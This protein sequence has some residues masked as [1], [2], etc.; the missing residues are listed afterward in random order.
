[1]SLGVLTGTTAQAEAEGGAEID[2]SMQRRHLCRL[3]LL[4]ALVK[5][6]NSLPAAK[7]PRAGHPRQPQPSKQQQQGSQGVTP[8]AMPRPSSNSCSLK[9]MI[10]SVGLSGGWPAGMR[11]EGVPRPGVLPAAAGG[12]GGCKVGWA[13]ELESSLVA[14]GRANHSNNM[15]LQSQAVPLL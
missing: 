15:S 7:L 1:M 6:Y 10:C 4:H 11:R 2:S 5:S 14:A 8:E 13:N 12:R 9:A 3:P